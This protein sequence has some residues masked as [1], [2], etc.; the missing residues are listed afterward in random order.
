MSH[1]QSRVLTS[2]ARGVCCCCCAAAAAAAVQILVGNKSDMADE[3]RAVPRSKGEALAKEYG[4][5][6]FETSAK[7]NVNVEE[8]R[9]GAWWC[10]FFLVV[11]F[12]LTLLMVCWQ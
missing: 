10:F 3:K 7:D 11:F 2:L 12:L 8:V 1:G 5:Q 4:I 9:A 6:F